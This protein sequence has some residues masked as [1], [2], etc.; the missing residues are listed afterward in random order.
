IL[1]TRTLQAPEPLRHLSFTHPFAHRP[2]VEFMLSIPREQVCRPDEPRRLMRRAFTGLL[3]D[4]IA[5]R[6][7]KMTYSAMYLEAIKPLPAEY[8]KQP[9][10]MRLV[11]LGYLDRENIAQRMTRLAQGLDCNETQLRHVILLET[12]LR[13]RGSAS[14]AISAE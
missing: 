14:P 7:S 12:W 10:E 1:D 5:R 4:K 11:Q 3:P 6:R 2:L 8:V 13:S 9:G